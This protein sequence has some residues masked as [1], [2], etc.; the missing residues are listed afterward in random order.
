[1][2]MFSRSSNLLL[3]GADHVAGTV[4]TSCHMPFPTLGT[5]GALRS[6]HQLKG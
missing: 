1:M 6:W 5:H 2:I 4:P 3:P